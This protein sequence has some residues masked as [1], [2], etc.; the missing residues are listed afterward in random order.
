M[1]LQKK[2]TLNKIILFFVCIVPSA[3]IIGAA[4]ADLFVSLACLTFLYYVISSKDLYYFKKKIILILAIFSL[5]S[6]FN[7]LFSEFPINSLRSSFFYFRFFI[8]ITVIWYLMDYEK[9]F[10]NYF[11]L[12]IILPLSIASLFSL[13]QVFDPGLEKARVLDFRISGFFGSE[14]I[15]GSYFLRLLTLCTGIYFYL[16]NKKDHLFYYL[17]FIIVCSFI[18]FISGERAA[19]SLLLVFLVLF[20]I[21][22]DINFLSKIKFIIFIITFLITIVLTLPGLKER[23]YDNTKNLLLEENKLQVFS[24]GHQEHY[25]SALKMFKD[26]KITGVGVRNFRLECRKPEYKDIG[27]NA[28]TTHPHNTYIQ[29]LAETG[30]VGFVFVMVLFTSILK[31]LIKNMYFMI[32]KKKKI[33]LSKTY[34]A[35]AIFINLFPFVPTG[36]FFNNWLSIVYFLPLAFFYYNPRKN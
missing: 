8:F 7:S 20:V 11:F 35:V 27:Q 31:F 25:I 17:I 10:V 33:N 26:N 15:Q 21:F 19:I 3:L 28:C 23:I 2:I 18:I 22:I 32:F 16:F 24:R 34:F 14:L 5:Y 36:S 4:V 6:I 13:Y 30:I 9:K 1:N 12:S 29:L